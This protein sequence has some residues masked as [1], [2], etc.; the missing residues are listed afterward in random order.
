MF[1]KGALLLPWPA[2]GEKD[3]DEKFVCDHT[4]KGCNHKQNHILLFTTFKCL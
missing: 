4:I 2:K 3:P 1:N